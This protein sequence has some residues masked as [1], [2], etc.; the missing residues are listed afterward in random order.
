[1][2]TLVDVIK[3]LIV[4]LVIDVIYLTVIRGGFMRQ[5]FSKF[6]GFHPKAWMYGFIAWV[7]LAYGLE[8]FAI[9]PSSNSNDAFVKGALL[10]LVIYGVYDF[11]NMA[12]IKGWTHQFVFQDVLWGTI[13]CGTIAYLRK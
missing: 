10:G 9:K 5:Y 12:T 4:F 1:M 2:I 11:T 13:L 7:L 6:G 8:K 3:T